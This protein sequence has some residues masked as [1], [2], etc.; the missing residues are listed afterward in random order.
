MTSTLG[1][2]LA[3]RLHPTVPAD[4]LRTISLM[5]RVR[6]VLSRIMGLLTMWV[7]RLG[8]TI[9]L[10]L[11]WTRLRRPVA[12]HWLWASRLRASVTVVRWFEKTPLNLLRLPVSCWARWVTV[13]TWVTR[14]PT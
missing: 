5:S 6:W 12:L 4:S 11:C 14:P 8:D 2:L 9:R 1:T 13:R 10:T 7:V 3:A